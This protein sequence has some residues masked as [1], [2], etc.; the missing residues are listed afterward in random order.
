MDEETMT[1]ITEE[2][3]NAFLTKWIYGSIAALGLLVFGILAPLGFVV[4]GRNTQPG[5]F[6]INHVPSLIMGSFFLLAGAVGN[7]MVQMYLHHRRTHGPDCECKLTR[8]P[9]KRDAVMGGLTGLCVLGLLIL[10]TPYILKA[11]I[12]LMSG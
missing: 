11:T 2:E 8:P 5:D 12:Y 7:T 9:R 1:P 4:F 10:A 6:I 3:M